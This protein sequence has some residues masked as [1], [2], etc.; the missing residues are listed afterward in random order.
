MFRLEHIL[1]LVRVSK[2]ATTLKNLWCNNHLSVYFTPLYCTT[3]N[4]K[5]KHLLDFV[6]LAVFSLTEHNLILSFFPTKSS[7]IN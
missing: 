7:F 5:V 2:Q 3:G 6:L 4:Q 1:N